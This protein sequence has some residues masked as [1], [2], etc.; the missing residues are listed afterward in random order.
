MKAFSP[1]MSMINEAQGTRLR[2][3]GKIIIYALR[4]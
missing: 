3:Q 4:N 2:A 1:A